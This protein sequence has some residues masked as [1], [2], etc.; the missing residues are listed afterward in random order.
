MSQ[1]TGQLLETGTLG[2]RNAAFVCFIAKDCKPYGDK[3]APM[4][5]ILMT[6][7]WDGSLGMFGGGVE[8]GETLV[9]AAIRE[10]MEEANTVVTADEMIP[11]CS[12]VVNDTLNSHLFVVYVEEAILYEAQLAAMSARDARSEGAGALVMHMH[13][14]TKENLLNGSLAKTV[15]EELMYLFDEKIIDECL[16]P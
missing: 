4:D 14:R 3:T 15:K 12:H 2:E 7:R 6:M 8:E 11:V 16:I 13:S 1:V 5:K 9:E 10:V